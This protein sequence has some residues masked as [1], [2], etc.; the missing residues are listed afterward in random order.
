AGRTVRVTLRF[1]RAARS[2]IRRAGGLRLTIAAT[3]TG[4]PAAK[5]TV[6]VRLPR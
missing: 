4:R 5:R 3:A 6:T 1:G 2:A